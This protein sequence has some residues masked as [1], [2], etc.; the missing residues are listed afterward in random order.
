MDTRIS[1]YSK[2][3]KKLFD[4]WTHKNYPQVY[5]HRIPIGVQF[6]SILGDVII[7]ATTWEGWSLADQIIEEAS[8][9]LGIAI[10]LEKM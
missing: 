1:F 9:A 5:S 3:D 8:E 7:R 4:Q 10:R 2:K 6:Y